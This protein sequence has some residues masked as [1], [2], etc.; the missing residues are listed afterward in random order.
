MVETKDLGV[1]VITDASSGR[2]HEEV[3]SA[4]IEGGATII[5]LR[6]KIMKEDDFR[7]TAD[8]VR[9]ITRE[10]GIPFIVNDRVEAALNCAADGVHIGQSDIPFDSV[11]KLVPAGMCVG[12]SVTCGKEADEASLLKPSYIGVGPVFTTDSKNDAAA[13]LG[14]RTLKSIV[15]RTDIPVVAIGGINADNLPSVIATGVSGIAVIKEV[16]GAV[17]MRSATRR[18]ADIWRKLGTDRKH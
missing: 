10:A 2:R 14:L 18:L 4:A 6:D 11:R 13:P 1:Y 9:S 7:K 12:L 15:D 17:D 16:A 5:Q 3:V 8:R